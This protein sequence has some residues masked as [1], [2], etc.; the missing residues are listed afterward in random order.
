MVGAA[1]LEV[2]SGGAVTFGEA[3]A[4][5]AGHSVQFMGVRAL[6]QGGWRTAIGAAGLGGWLWGA[7]FSEGVCRV[8]SLLVATAG[9]SDWGWGT[10]LLFEA[11]WQLPA[12]PLPG[13]PEEEGV[14]EG[15]GDRRS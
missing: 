1:G 8:L 6:T 11:S 4:A 15:R 14:G 12:Y 9:A 7:H 3:W 2:I 10:L 5:L 13:V